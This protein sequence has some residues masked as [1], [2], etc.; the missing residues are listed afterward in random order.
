[1]GYSSKEILDDIHKSNPLPS[2]G[3]IDKS[4]KIHNL[5]VQIDSLLNEDEKNA[6][7]FL[8]WAIKTC[9]EPNGLKELFDST[10]VVPS[11]AMLDTLTESN[12]SFTTL[13]SYD[14]FYIKQLNTFI[15]DSEKLEYVYLNKVLTFF[16]YDI[17]HV[18]NDALIIPP[19]GFIKKNQSIN[20][21]N[22]QTTFLRSLNHIYFIKN[23]ETSPYF[24]FISLCP[25][26]AYVDGFKKLFPEVYE[27]VMNRG[28]NDDVKIGVDPYV[29]NA[30]VGLVNKVF[31]VNGR[32]LNISKFNI[33]AD[34]KS[35]EK[36]KSITR[37]TIMVNKVKNSNF[38]KAVANIKNKVSNSYGIKQLARKLM[39]S[40]EP[41]KDDIIEA[42][43]Q[44]HPEFQGKTFKQLE[45]EWKTDNCKKLDKRDDD[46]IN[47]FV[48]FV[49]TGK[50]FK[51]YWD[52]MEDKNLMFDVISRKLYYMTDAKQYLY[53]W[54]KSQD[55]LCLKS[56]DDYSNYAS[57][58]E[59]GNREQDK[60]DMESFENNREESGIDR[61]VDDYLQ[62]VD[63]DY[64]EPE[65]KFEQDYPSIKD[66]NELS[67][68]VNVVTLS[69]PNKQLLLNNELG[70]CYPTSMDINKFKEYKN[71]LT[72]QNQDS[73]RWQIYNDLMRML[74]I[75]QNES[76][77]YIADLLMK[78]ID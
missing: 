42:V 50:D 14:N 35:A 26:K 18:F 61:Y 8:Y 13:T 17:M 24:N 28:F 45:Q 72:E 38:G 6:G 3:K 5:N 9:I 69:L 27:N 39:E 62:T 60:A 47:G 4:S 54:D 16:N 2:K 67:R 55:Y 43:S 74:K 37:G 40:T 10:N 29:I 59:S 51:N 58:I 23:N 63:E 66:F 68:I 1:M 7:N 12:K 31:S 64:E 41:I 77:S 30:F 56:D 22:K 70:Y 49:K 65:D 75:Q 11:Q 15:K 57:N 71:S 21:T 44:E 76:I 73:Y 25:K 19:M 33:P 78:F 46:F 36:E 52:N 32:K 34:K 20:D 53:I 48:N